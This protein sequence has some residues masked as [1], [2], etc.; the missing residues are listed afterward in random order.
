MQDNKRRA[1]RKKF[2]LEK[3]KNKNKNKKKRREEKLNLAENVSSGKGKEAP[4]VSER[5]D[6]LQADRA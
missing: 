5:A 3:E 2:C 1:S 6:V 4:Q